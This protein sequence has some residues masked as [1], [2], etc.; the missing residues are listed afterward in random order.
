MQAVGDRRGLVRELIEAR[1]DG[2][3]KLYLT[4]TALHYRRARP[5]IFLEGDYLAAETAGGKAEH[6]CAYV[7]QRGAARVLVVVPRLVAGLVGEAGAV[8]VGSPVW[9]ETVLRI[10]ADGRAAH[11]R[12]VLTGDTVT[13]KEEAGREVLRVADVLSDCPVAL[14][15]RVEA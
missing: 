6:L 12:N 3:I 4:M 13:S 8:P 2:R 14:L 1:Q 15:E 9:D 7:R 5:D 10:S 11:Y